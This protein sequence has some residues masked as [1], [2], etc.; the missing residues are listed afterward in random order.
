M[1]TKHTQGEWKRSSLR[2]REMVVDDFGC[3]IA[4]LN[5]LQ[6]EFRENAK[7]IAAAPDLLRVLINVKSYID[8][9]EEFRDMLSEE[10]NEA[11]KK[12]TL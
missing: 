4:Q 9:D 8:L 10:I 11:I 2:D 12:A 6:P 7:L 3:Q 5:N 1:E